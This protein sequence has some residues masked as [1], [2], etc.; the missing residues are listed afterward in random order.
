MLIEWF[1]NLF[2][3]IVLG[4]I[5][6]ALVGCAA[7]LVARAMVP[8]E[9]SM[10]FRDAALLGMLGSLG[11]SAVATVIN[12]EGGYLSGGPSALLFSVVGAMLIIVLA[13]Q[14]RNRSQ[15]RGQ[16]TRS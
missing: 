8:D 12:S 10:R 5:N 4:L 2:P 16:P 13:A 14:V 7:G 6:G 11:G 3:F 15:V 9:Q 1:M